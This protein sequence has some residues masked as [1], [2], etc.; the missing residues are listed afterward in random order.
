MT[1]FYYGSSVKN[2]KRVNLSEICVV[3]WN[4]YNIISMFQFKY[5]VY[6]Q[7]SLDYALGRTKP[8][9]SHSI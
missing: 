4:Q 6:H 8:I 7:G 5:K 3:N 9:V 2:Q 1:V